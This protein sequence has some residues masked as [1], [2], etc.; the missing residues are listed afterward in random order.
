MTNDKIRLCGTVAVLFGL[1]T[2]H[3]GLGL[4]AGG[5]IIILGAWDSD[6][7]K[8]SPPAA[9]D[10]NAGS[11]EPALL[12]II[13]RHHRLAAEIRFLLH[14]EGAGPSL[15]QLKRC[16]VMLREIAGLPQE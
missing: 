8:E 14:N 2:I 16:D 1:V 12:D 7:P 3:P 10:V 13:D 15:A 5:L 6:E 9:S 4:I 11:D